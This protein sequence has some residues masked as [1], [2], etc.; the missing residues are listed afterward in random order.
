MSGPV[1]AMEAL[2]ARGFSLALESPLP[3]NTDDPRPPLRLRLD[4][5]ETP[6]DDLRCEIVEHRDDSGTPR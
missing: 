4:G 5:P 2:Y 3:A 1:E 6:P